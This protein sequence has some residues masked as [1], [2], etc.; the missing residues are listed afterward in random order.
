MK[1]NQK[2][3]FGLHIA[4]ILLCVSHLGSLWMRLTQVS[5]EEIRL[6]EYEIHAPTAHHMKLMENYPPL[7]DVQLPSAQRQT[8][9]GQIG[10]IRDELFTK[11]GKIKVRGIFTVIDS[12]VALVEITSAGSPVMQEVHEK[13]MLQ[14]YRVIAIEAKRIRLLG[15][16]S[17]EI[18]EL[19]IFDRNN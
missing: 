17:G 9:T 1:K 6:D 18:I 19:I 16:E 5:S 7:F 10:T 3:V 11:K 12:Q 8:D 13:D 2:F 4:L 14:G 15:E